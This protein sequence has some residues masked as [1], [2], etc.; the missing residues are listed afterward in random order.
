MARSMGNF[1]F[2]FIAIVVLSSVCCSF[3]F[4]LFM[5][6]SNETSVKWKETSG[7]S[8]VQISA[9]T[10]YNQYEESEEVTRSGA[11]CLTFEETFDNLVASSNN[12]FLVMPPKAA[13]SSMKAFTEKCAGADG[14][15]NP[16][17]DDK[18]MEDLFHARL[19]PQ[20]IITSHLPKTPKTKLVR[21]IQNAP[22]K[23]LVVYLHRNDSNR[24]ISAIRYV[25]VTKL[26]GKKFGINPLIHDENNY[27]M[28]G[29]RCIINEDHVINNIIKPKIGEIGG[30][31]DST[32]HCGV[33]SAIEDNFPTMVFIH[34][35]QAE[36]VQKV[37]AK[38]HCP[39]LLNT[40]FR[41]NIGGQH[42]G[43]P[44]IEA[45][46]RVKKK[47]GGTEL[48]ELGKW[49]DA[50]RDLLEIVYQL[51][52]SNRDGKTCLGKTRNMEDDLFSCGDE[53]LQV[54][55]DTSF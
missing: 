35:K 42:E 26:C 21:L 50:K 6:D 2:P 54:T 15:D 24:I 10:T 27:T 49:L 52:E 39:D 28:D 14:G 7:S 16:L 51:K 33:Y 43:E 29:T 19:M 36:K 5:L 47:E 31:S 40:P 17:R 48:V 12:I 55:R 20:K 8:G 22:R 1:L 3:R 9:A 32:L 46:L 25:L 53:I 45:F 37:F 44:E 41:D 34:Y 23:S 18:Q 13:G 11:K 4:A 38:Y 30:G